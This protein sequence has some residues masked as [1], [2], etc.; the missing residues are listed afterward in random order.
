MRVVLEAD[1]EEE[2]IEIIE[3]IEEDI[4]TGDVDKAESETVHGEESLLDL[5]NNYND[6]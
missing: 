1:D 3:R 4:S 6:A 5:G 2:G